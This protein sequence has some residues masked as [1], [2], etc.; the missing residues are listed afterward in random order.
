M[1]KIVPSP[2]AMALAVEPGSYGETVRTLPG[3]ARSWWDPSSPSVAGGLARRS[4]R[5]GHPLRGPL[6]LQK[7]PR[8]RS[9][10]LCSCWRACHPLTSRFGGYSYCRGSTSRSGVGRLPRRSTRPRAPSSRGSCNGR[11]NA[12]R[13]PWP[14]ARRPMP[15]TTACRRASARRPGT[16]PIWRPSGVSVGAVWRTSRPVPCGFALVSRSLPDPSG[17]RCTSLADHRPRDCPSDGVYQ[18]G[19]NSSHGAPHERDLASW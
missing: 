8:D 3:A 11:K 1:R 15:E 7:R 4:P 14:G 2:A 12:P 10:C 6:G 9:G 13:V 16:P 17:S 19:R 5:P 18:R